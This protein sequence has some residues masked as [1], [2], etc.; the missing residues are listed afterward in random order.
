MKQ[1][2]IVGLLLLFIIGISSLYVCA[3]DR[4]RSAQSGNRSE[5]TQGKQPVS[6]S[7][8]NKKN[9]GTI[10][11]N[12]ARFKKEQTKVK[13]TR[14]SPGNGERIIQNNKTYNYSNGRFY[15]ETNGKY[16]HTPP[17]RG[18]RIKTLPPNYQRIVFGNIFYY[19]FEGIFYSDMN[20]YYEV[21]NPEIGTIV[22][23][24]PT[25]YE[26]VIYNGVTYYEYNG[27]IYEKVRT[28][29]GKGYQVVGYLD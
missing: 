19:F 11:R 14:Q 12:D 17:P 28:S 13:A 27:I 4:N 22:E 25:D 10:S 21:V 15:M 23:A 2:K 3:Q 24:L 26:K 6:P 5:V 8:N 9:I 7:N 16:I 20:G 29:Y 18:L 1:R